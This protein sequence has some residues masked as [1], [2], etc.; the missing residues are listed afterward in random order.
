MFNSV[1]AEDCYLPVLE[2]VQAVLRHSCPREGASPRVGATSPA[3]R[4]IALAWREDQTSALARRDR[5][6]H[7]VE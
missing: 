1:V 4:A 2:K 5:A 7:V 6:L 3:A